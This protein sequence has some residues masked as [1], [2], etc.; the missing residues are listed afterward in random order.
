MESLNCSRSDRSGNGGGLHIVMFPWLAQGHILPCIELSKRLLDQTNIKISIIS[1]PLNIAQIKLFFKEKE[2]NLNL[3]ELQLPCVDGLPPGM[4]NT[5]NLPT[6]LTLPFHNAVK[7]LQK[8]LEILLGQIA[9]DIVIFDHVLCWI[10]KVTLKL[11]IKS[12][13]F[14]THSTAYAGYVFC[15]ARRSESKES[16][17]DGLLKPPADFPF[18]PSR[19]RQSEMAA[20]LPI[21]TFTYPSGEKFIDLTVD[22]YYNCAAVAIKSCYELEAKFI[23]YFQRVTGNTVI[24]VGV[25]LPRPYPVKQIE[26][27]DGMPDCLRW[28]KNQRPGSVVYVSFGSEYFLSE[29]LIEE[30]AEGLE[31]SL[32]PFLWVLRLA[33]YLDEGM[34]EV[35]RRVS[36]SLPRGFES[37]VA[38]RGMVVSGWAP[39]QEILCHPSTGAFVSHC[40][41][42]SL[43]E[44]LGAGL[45]L[46]AWPMQLD[47]GLNVEVFVHEFQ[48]GVEVERGS[49]G[50]V[51]RG[52]ICKAVKMVMDEEEGRFVRS[53]AAEMGN[54]F[55]EKLLEEQGSQNKYVDDLV[56]LFHRLKLQSKK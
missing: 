31:A 10:S 3:L 26:I 45:P 48:V 49:D 1:T 28:L 46:I 14:F 20:L 24:P 41:W 15:P 52:D 55:K 56:K 34:D 21:Y 37:R 29:K 18:T 8:P 38:E 13:V 5:S 7:E 32:V 9:P 16:T 39:Q 6:H 12:I 4:E 11:K 30:I 23:D 53:K 19:Y 17:A 25:L 27:H 44:G 2:L 40:G 51:S 47:Q 36:D 35:K 42:S 22:C 33:G 50:S 43:M 54:L